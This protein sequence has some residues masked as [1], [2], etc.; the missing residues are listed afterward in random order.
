MKGTNCGVSRLKSTGAHWRPYRMTFVTLGPKVETNAGV[1]R[2]RVDAWKPFTPPGNGASSPLVVTSGNVLV[3][4]RLK[5][6]STLCEPRSR[7]LKIWWSYLNTYLSFEVSCSALNWKQLMLK[8]S[9]PQPESL[10]GSGIWLRWAVS[11]GFSV[12]NGTPAAVSRL[13]VRVA[14]PTT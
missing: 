7:F 1:I 11:S 14:P 2:F 10:L 5:T 9:P 8:P 4:T 6:N 13:T 3:R 12:L